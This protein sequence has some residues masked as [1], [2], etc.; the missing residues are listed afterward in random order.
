[1]W[2]KSVG[3]IMYWQYRDIGNSGDKIQNE[4]TPNQKNKAK[5][6]KSKQ[7]QNSETI[8]LWGDHV[9]IMN[10]L[11]ILNNPLYLYCSWFVRVYFDQKKK[12]FLKYYL[13]KIPKK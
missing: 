10:Q 1:M 11:E 5:Q 12:L 6:R 4:E 2:E 9:F 13:K 7:T 3:I 8:V